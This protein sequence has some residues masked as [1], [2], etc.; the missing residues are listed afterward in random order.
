MSDD[1]DISITST[2]PS[3]QESEYEVETI[4]AE[5]EF[6]D[7]IKYL[8][9]WAN[10]PIER[11]TWEPPESFC[12]E[13][14]LIDWNK[15]KNSIAE[16][17][18]PAFDLVSFENHLAALER[19]KH[20]RKQRR[21]AK[22]RR[23]GLDGAPQSHPA[24]ESPSSNNVPDPRIP[25]DTG[26]NDI[27]VDR[28]KA[29]SGQTPRTNAS[30]GSAQL[31]TQ[32]LPKRPPPPVLFGTAP[33]PTR[34]KRMNSS[35]TPKLFNLSTRW[36]YEKA[37]TYEP[38]PDVN[39]LQLIRPS[40]WPARTGLTATKTGLYSVN[41]PS[42]END[43][44]TAR[45]GSHKVVSPTRD[46]SSSA[47]LGTYDVSSPNESDLSS[48]KAGSHDL[49][50]SK[51]SNASL[52]NLGLYNVSSP[53]SVTWGRLATNNVNGSHGIS[54]SALDPQSQDVSSP[55]DLDSDNETQGQISQTREDWALRRVQDGSYKPNDSIPDTYRP[56]CG[57]DTWIPA[58]PLQD[59]WCAS[60]DS[61]KPDTIPPIHRQELEDYPI[62]KLPTREPKPG[63]YIVKSQQQYFWNPGE[64]LVYLYYGLEK[65]EIGSARLCGL[66]PE[67]RSRL[68]ST[69]RGSRINIWFQHTCNLEEYNVLCENTRN[70]HKY[71]DAWLEGFD[72]TEPSIYRIGEELRRNELVAISYP[73]PDSRMSNVLLAYSPKS[74]DFAFL[75]ADSAHFRTSEDVFLNVAVRSQ[76]R[77]FD[78][79][80][81]RRERKRLHA[82]SRKP[83]PFALINTSDPPSRATPTGALATRP[84]SVGVP[85][86]SAPEAARPVND[87]SN[88]P[89]HIS[90]DSDV[91]LPKASAA[92]DVA[93][94][95]DA[96][97]HLGSTN[98]TSVTPELST[99][100]SG[101]DNLHAAPQNTLRELELV[102]VAVQ[103]PAQQTGELLSTSQVPLP[104]HRT[105]QAATETSPIT[106][107]ARTAPEAAPGFPRLGRHDA[108]M[109][110]SIAGNV[111]SPSQP[112]ENILDLDAVFKE[113]FGVTYD[114]LATVNDAEKPTKAQVFY[115]MFPAGS[116]VVQEEYEVM[117]EFLRRHNA[118]TYSNRLP[119]DW[120][121]F[122]RT[123]HKGVV[124]AHE[125]FMN[126]HALPFI[127][128]LIHRNV[129][130]WSLSLRTPLQYA[131]H[132]TYFQ[133]LFPHGGVILITEDFM[134]RDPDATLII[135]A[136]LK[137]W[138]KQ[139]FPGS[140]KIMFRPNILDWLLKQSESKDPFRQGIRVASTERTSGNNLSGA[141]GEHN[142]DPVISLDAIPL[143]GS[144]TEDDDADI[145]KGLT[146]EQRNA[147]HLGEFFAGWAI[148]NNHRFRRFVMLTAVKPLPRW[149]AWQHIEIRYGA[150]DFMKTFKVEY[151]TYWDKVKPRLGKPGLSSEA[152]SQNHNP[153]YTPRTPGA[154][155]PSADGLDVS[156]AG[157]FSHGPSRLKYPQPYQ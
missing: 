26:F 114:L 64:L 75:N 102:N 85:D 39:K 41:R 74:S 7:G 44:N 142:E 89:I 25:G 67:S 78:T 32:Q 28:S 38:P 104:K 68:M 140:W 137:D 51:Q 157:E 30:T 52:V 84:R 125:S 33:A 100:H 57:A 111:K 48:V 150:K 124:L 97:N 101:A 18:R 10:Y 9:K 29:S 121:R 31:Q 76:L 116:E 19:A 71:S 109:A 130:F 15:K 12:N 119:E 45:L 8:V 105:P 141:S 86:V 129:S 122:A 49:N 126:Y 83:V 54:D 16:G 20:D 151:K 61:V 59:S 147:D 136:W 155:G 128:D 94:P 1:D 118:V 152:K 77:G 120:E 112:S 55:M 14:T 113:Q 6:D 144:P 50:S 133:R 99:Q 117:H 108:S 135:L 36:K 17:K 35:E 146:Q 149:E 148:V 145:H 153:A 23:L 21:A 96:A 80:T 47:K 143:Y 62:R 5:L 92:P 90:R 37:K 13:Q 63:A 22:R 131:D 87:M 34:P 154:N 115:L 3:E 11:C 73:A 58:R 24:A 4:L 43:A 46:D 81:A 82:G 91:L 134:L 42:T 27:E 138:I 60:H 65:K 110:Q 53:K 98:T 156:R 127:K 72:D 79:I 2:A 103:D 132:P 106:S 95:S 56:A 66:S 70:N 107:E 69:K 40:D 88:H 93:K 139:K 123:I